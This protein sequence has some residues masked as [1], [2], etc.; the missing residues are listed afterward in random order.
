MIHTRIWLKVSILNP[1][2]LSLLL[3]LFSCQS[4]KVNYQP[5][6]VAFFTPAKPILTATA[7][8]GTANMPADRSLNEIINPATGTFTPTT[9]PP[10]IIATLQPS[11]QIQ[12]GDSLPAVAARFQLSEQDLVFNNLAGEIGYLPAGEVILLREDATEFVKTEPFMPDSEF[13]F[14]PTATGFDI[15]AYLSLTG[16]FLASHQEYLRSSGWTS[17]AE[18]I[19]RVALENSINPRILLSILE[20]E[21]HLVFGQP[22]EDINI[23]YVLGN[24]DYRRKGLYLQLS[25]LADQLSAGYYGWREGTLMEIKS[26]DGIIY[27]LSPYLNAGSV[28]L[29]YYYAQ[30]HPMVQLSEYI[31]PVR[32]L[33]GLHTSMFGDPWKRA[34]QVEPLLPP[35]LSQPLMQ[36]PFEAGKLWSYSSGPHAAWEKNGAMAALDFAPASAE[37]GCVPSK[38]WVTAVADGIVVRTGAGIVIQDI[39][40]WLGQESD[41]LEQTGWVVIYMHV[42]EHERVESG[43]RL[44]A[45]DRIGHPSCEGG[46]ANGTHVHLARK[47]NG[48]WI[49]AGG[50]LPFTLDGWVAVAG[51]KPYEGTLENGSQIRTAHPNGSIFTQITRPDIVGAE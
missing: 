40:P 38:A 30:R 27:R 49:L 6:P 20:Y 47:F 48:E 32:G 16:G 43:T 22:T 42:E 11:Y 19:Q 13:V 9:N 41:G 2:I 33:P 35:G 44:K 24:E 12:S 26:A 3:L 39:D 34:G 36:L 14:S 29:I 25:W 1:G 5:T 46:P 50:P 51:D 21:T 4:Y 15:A 7:A 31:D 17:A 45:G 23:E 37:S 18:I 28:G 8:A 10:T